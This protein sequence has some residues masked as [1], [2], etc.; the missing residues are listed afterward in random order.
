MSTSSRNSSPLMASHSVQVLA[1]SLALILSTTAHAAWI[2][3]GVPVCVYPDCQGYPVEIV[4]DGVRG[5]YLVW[6][7]GF[8]PGSPKVQHL[9]ENGTIVSGWPIHGTC[10]GRDSSGCAGLALIN[11]GQGGVYV[12]W[13]DLPAY[14]IYLQHFLGNGEIATG[15]PRE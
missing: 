4:G 1:C 10:P 2:H 9:D 12:S 3:D 15:W 7:D 13:V 6:K 8:E 11:D 14:N 5:A